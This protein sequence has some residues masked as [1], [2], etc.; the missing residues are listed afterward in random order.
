[1]SVILWLLAGLLLAFALSLFLMGWIEKQRTA[2]DDFAALSS[3]LRAHRGCNLAIAARM[4]DL[5]QQGYSAFFTPQR[6]KRMTHLI[7]VRGEE[8]QLEKA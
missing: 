5:T 7:R 2:K 6:M 4:D 1:M 8:K 3:A